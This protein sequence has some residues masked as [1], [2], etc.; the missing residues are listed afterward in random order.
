[1]KPR[2]DAA[3]LALWRAAVYRLLAVAFAYPMAIR[4]AA[5]AC[6][7][8]AAA[9]VSRSAA[10]RAALG[11]LASAARRYDV[12]A[13]AAEYGVLF[14]GPV[15]C[16]PYEGAWGPRS[17]SGK[18]TQLAD[19][20]GFHA[21]F[22]LGPALAQPD[23]EDHVA[24]E[25]EFMSVLALREAYAAAARHADGRTI[26]RDAQAA[27][28]R[29]HL[30][31]WAQTFAAEV[32]RQATAP[33][34]RTAARLLDAWVADEAARLGVTPYRADG[35]AAAEPETFTCPRAEEPAAAE[36]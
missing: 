14:D 8:R 24:A 5:L 36:S 1:M 32:Q 4:T 15:R 23:M 31:R 25:C 26:V 34:Y 29:D 30:G 17:M 28:L 21:A 13:V 3:G 16:P 18:A 11:E 19:I 12:G 27:F 33:L 35:L 20:A 2:D 6:R 22:G 7:A 10:I 9:R